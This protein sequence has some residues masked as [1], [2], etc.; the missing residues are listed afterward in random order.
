MTFI[1]TLDVIHVSGCG[2]PGFKL[3]KNDEGFSGETCNVGS[4]NDPAT[5]TPVAPLLVASC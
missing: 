3:L 2:T 1:F 4:C 5:S